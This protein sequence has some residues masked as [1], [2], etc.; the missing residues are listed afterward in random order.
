MSSYYEILEVSNNANQQEIKKAY[1][2]LARRFHPD[3]NHGKEAA[4]HFK[5]I[6]KAYEVLSDPKKRNIYDT[7]GND[8]FVGS[9]S[10]T[11]SESSFVFQDIF[12]NFFGTNTQSN[13]KLSRKK[14]GQNILLETTISLKDT[15]FG[16]QKKIEVYGF[17][18]CQLCKGSCCKKGFYV[19]TCNECNGSGKVQRV[20]RSMLGQVI[21]TSICEL[22]QGYGSIINQPCISCRAEGRIRKRRIIKIKIPAGVSNGSR[23]QLKE[24]GEAGVAGGNAGDLYIEIKVHNHLVFKRDKN[25]LITNVSIPMIAAAL[26]TKLTIDTFDGQQTVDVK[27]GSQSGEVLL[28]KNLGVTRLGSKKRGNL[29]IR[30]QVETPVKLNS[31]QKTLLKKLANLRNENYKHLTIVKTNNQSMFARLRDKFGNL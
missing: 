11:S 16:V 12:E 20:V 7:T 3:V 5:L 18:V 25:D 14:N 10:Y 2:K 28:L 1:R 31:S 19:N 27:P 21:S 8:S 26:G 29:K 22:C 6:T 17:V 9:S 24:Q 4:E 15:V 13:E 30:L 23:I